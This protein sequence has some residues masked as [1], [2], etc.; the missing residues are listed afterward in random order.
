MA[1]MILTEWKTEPSTTEL[2]KNYL[3]KDLLTPKIRS[4][5]SSSPL[6][7]CIKSCC[8]LTPAVFSE[9]GGPVTQRCETA[10]SNR[11]FEG[12]QADLKKMTSST[13]YLAFP[14]MK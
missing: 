4:I 8:T 13:P 2:L 5:I 3:I 14:T 9:N 10:H 7:R 11:K 12:R 6:N 1:D